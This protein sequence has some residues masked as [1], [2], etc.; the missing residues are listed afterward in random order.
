M[1]PHG[2]T[3]HEVNEVRFMQ[4]LIFAGVFSLYIGFSAVQGYLLHSTRGPRYRSAGWIM[5]CAYALLIWI[6]TSAFII[7][8]GW[9]PISLIILCLVSGVATT[10]LVTFRPDWIPAFVWTRTFNLRYLGVTMVVV[11]LASMIPWLPDPNFGAL[12]L[13]LAACM[14]GFRALRDVTA[15]V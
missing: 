10:S 14:A 4:V 7:T 13:G 2:C 9:L 1:H 3:P 11:A 15:R 5:V 12:T 8:L 6:P